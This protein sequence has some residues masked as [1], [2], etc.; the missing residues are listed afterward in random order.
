M[1]TYL[2]IFFASTLLFGNSGQ[3]RPYP[4]AILSCPL[5]MEGS[6]ELQES[7]LNSFNYSESHGFD[8]SGPRGAVA[9]KL[10]ISNEGTNSICSMKLSAMDK[11]F[12]K[13][14]KWVMS[15]TSDQSP[16][17]SLGD[18][19]GKS[20]QFSSRYLN[21]IA[22]CQSPSEVE[23]GNKC[24]NEPGS[25][26]TTNFDFDPKSPKPLKLILYPGGFTV[27][28]YFAAWIS[29]KYKNKFCVEIDNN[30]KFPYRCETEIKSPLEIKDQT[31]SLL[32][33]IK[34]DGETLILTNAEGEPLV[35]A[36][37]KT[38]LSEFTLNNGARIKIQGNLVAPTR[39]SSYWKPQ[40][41]QPSQEVRI[42][43]NG[44][45]N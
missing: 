29:Y 33:N 17:I 24:Y 18:L 30:A 12:V 10:T 14:L 40:Q 22:K 39:F 1:K 37:I 7:D 23:P 16:E 9:M 11:S 6:L 15:G 43:C 8:G 13:K 38:D 35:S 19:G 34:V 42:D 36:T 26:F 4:R 20:C 27:E 3:C 32:G 45:T 21:S 25:D 44:P 31:N 28:G 5:D 41:L 2:M